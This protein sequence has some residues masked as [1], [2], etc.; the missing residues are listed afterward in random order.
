MDYILLII[1]FFILIK[2]ADFLVEGSSSIAKN[3]GISPLVIWLTVVA[4]GTSAP[5]FFVSILSAVR[6]QTD[7]ALGNII[8]SNIANV[9]LILW[10]ASFIYPIKAKASTIY[11]E[12]PFSLIA[13]IALF[14]MAY[15]TYFSSAT[16]NVISRSDGLILLLFFIIFFSYTFGISKN[17]V[18][19]EQEEIKTLS[20]GKTFLYLILGITWLSL[21]AYFLVNSAQVIAAQFWVPESFIGLTVIAFGTSL[22][23][24]ATAVMASMK[25]QVDIVVWNVVGSNIFNILLVLS[26]TAVVSDIPVQGTIITD[27]IIELF[28]ITLLIVFLFFI[29]KKWVLTRVEWGIFLSLYLIYVGYLFISLS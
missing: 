29:W 11:K 25:K 27:I 10:V 28:V 2:W 4:F 8:G 22:P 16:T 24:L 23:E 17:T 3:F 21:G 12:V 19:S 26:T 1:G 7:L 14:F 5:E 18:E 9:L 13:S 15:D 6:G 20:N